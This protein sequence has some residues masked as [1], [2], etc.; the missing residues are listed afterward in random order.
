MQIK[1]DLK[2]RYENQEKTKAHEIAIV[3]A[4]YMERAIANGHPYETNLVGKAMI[5]GGLNLDF[6][7]FNSS[8]FR[9]IASV[10]TVLVTYWEYGDLVRAWFR[11]L[12]DIYLF[13]EIELEEADAKFANESE[14]PKL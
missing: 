7:D 3:L 11:K 4:D 13:T 2:E 1:Q 9:T 10:S 5:Y 6:K 12:Y 8:D 14:K